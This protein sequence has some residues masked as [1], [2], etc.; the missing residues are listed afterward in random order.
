VVETVRGAQIGE[1]ARVDG[2][3]A[4]SLLAIDGPRGEI[5][6]PLALDICVSID[7]AGKRILVDPPEGLLEVNET[8]RES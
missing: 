7:V 4:G 2:G 6:I 5:L 3:S 8:N 1:V